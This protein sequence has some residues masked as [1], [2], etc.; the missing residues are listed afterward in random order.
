MCAL[1]APA[2]DTVLLSKATAP[3]T[4]C[5]LT[6]PAAAT[7]PLSM[8]CALCLRLHLQ[9]RVRHVRLSCTVR[10]ALADR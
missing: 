1:T 3:A 10:C 2:T 7:V 9:D 6:A 5:A 4:M 8:A